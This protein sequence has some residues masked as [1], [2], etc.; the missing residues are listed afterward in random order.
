[1]SWSVAGIAGIVSVIAGVVVAVA[2][3]LYGEVQRRLRPKLNI[4][5]KEVVFHYRPSNPGSRHVQA[6]I[7]FNVA[8]DGRSAAH[9]VRCEIRLDERHLE[10]DDMHGP[11]HDFFA[12]RLGPSES[13]PLQVNVAILAYGPTEA[14]YV[15]VC[16]EVGESEGTIRFEVPER[17]PGD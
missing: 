13:Q 1:M 16:D 15:C 9:N 17:E 8:N 14:H 11:N 6:G 10:L 7:V 4:S 2:T 5:F 3:V 12:A